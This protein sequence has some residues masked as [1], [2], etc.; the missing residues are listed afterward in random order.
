VKVPKVLRRTESGERSWDL[1]SNLLESRIVFLSGP[2][3][4]E[5]ASS[6]VAQLLFL[7]SQDPQR[8]ITLYINS[9]GGYITAGLAIYDTMQYIQPDVGTL[10]MGRAASVAAFLLCSGAKGKRFSLA[11]SSVLIHQ[12]SAAI[13]GRGSDI[14]IH[15]REVMRTKTVV[16]EL[17]ARHTGQTVEK[18]RQDTERDR[19]LN[20][21][22]AREYGIVDVVLS[23]PSR[24]V[25][26]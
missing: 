9:P 17:M 26:R 19:I 25:G 14:E 6:I 8:D 5:T 7:E 18:V 13:A 1:I 4:E 22:E 24:T 2:V 16:T 15:A 10:C 21:D 11:N 12:P 3:L 23:P 20:A